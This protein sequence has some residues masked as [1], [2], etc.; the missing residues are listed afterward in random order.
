M[1]A[2]FAK[3]S[4]WSPLLMNVAKNSPMSCSI[5]LNSMTKRPIEVAVR[6]F[7]TWSALALL[8]NSS[9]ICILIYWLRECVSGGR[10]QEPNVRAQRA[11]LPSAAATGYATQSLL[12]LISCCERWAA[13]KNGNKRTTVF[14]KGLFERPPFEESRSMSS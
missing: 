2:M 13:L 7:C 9:G 3:Y 6:T 12:H 5:L 4:V 8:I 10:L 1:I 14:A 11:T